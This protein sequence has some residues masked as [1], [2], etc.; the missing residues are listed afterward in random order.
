MALLAKVVL[1]ATDGLGLRRSRGKTGLN[2]HSATKWSKRLLA[3]GLEG[4]KDQPGR[5]RPQSITPEE[6]VGAV[7]RACTM[8][9]DGGSRWSVCKMAESIGHSK[10]AVQK[11][12]TEGVIKPLKTKNWC[13]KS[14]DSEFEQKQAAII[15]LSLNPPE[16]AL[17]LSV[18]E[19]SQIQALDRIQPLLPL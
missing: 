16:N 2:W 15:G 12:L 5:G 11:I 7:V 3:H 9:V 13:G 1:L 17:V 4:L 14:L 8:P 6:G 18:N 10:S 19:K